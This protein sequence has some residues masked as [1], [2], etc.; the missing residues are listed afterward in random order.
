MT[1]PASLQDR[2]ALVTGAGRRRGIGAATAVHLAR[3]GAAV[4]VSDLVPVG[5][6]T[7]RSPAPVLEETAAT[8]PGG[9]GATPASS[10]STSPIR[11]RSRRRS[12]RRRSTFGG[13]DVLVNNA[14]T[15]IGVGEFT[16][17]TDD[18]WELS[19]LINVMGP[20]RQPSRAP[21]TWRSAAA[22]SSTSPRPQA[23]PPSPGYGA[24]TVTKHAVVGLTR[25][26]AAELGPR[27]NP[28]ERHRAGDDPHRPGR[29]RARA[30]RRL[31]PGRAST[32]P[33]APSWR[34]SRSDGSALP[35]TSPPPSPGLP[36]R[37]PTCRA[38]CCP[39]PAPKTAGLN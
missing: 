1:V 23:W 36:I 15:G 30:G 8:N 22:A 14:G 24:Y 39:S 28:G 16:E 26:L 37:R 7:A 9:R 34:A 17:V 29:S 6:H 3:A 33:P 27:G 19:W 18:R 32:T 35:T 2:V 4:V 21:P 31:R 5:G 10:P 12:R 13:L 11:P 20:M 25:L 38:P